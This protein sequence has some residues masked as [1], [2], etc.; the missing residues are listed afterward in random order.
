MC[1]PCRNL[2]FQEQESMNRSSSCDCKHNQTC[3]SS[4][5]NRSITSDNSPSKTIFSTRF[6]F[7]MSDSY[8][9]GL[10]KGSPLSSNLKYASIGLL[11]L[12]A[13][14]KERNCGR[15]QF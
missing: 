14:Y 8:L 2:Q 10:N 6:P 12:I 13:C 11:L 15:A 7:F 3:Y 1:S 5:D 4:K 9:T